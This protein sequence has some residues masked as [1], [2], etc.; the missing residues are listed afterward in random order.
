LDVTGSRGLITG[1]SSRLRKYPASK[2][3]SGTDAA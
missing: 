3:G 2:S 1:L